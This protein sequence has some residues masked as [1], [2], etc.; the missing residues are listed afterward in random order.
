MTFHLMKK[1][2]SCIISIH[3]FTCKITR[4]TYLSPCKHMRIEGKCLTCEVKEDDDRDSYKR[5]TYMFVVNITNSRRPE[6]SVSS[7][8]YF[9]TDELGIF[10]LLF[11]LWL[12]DLFQQCFLKFVNS[13]YNGSMDLITV[14]I[15]ILAVIKF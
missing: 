3:F 4:Y 2:L 1:L 8:F 9:N 6:A 12:G 7:H 14:V 13:F 11:L 15:Y 5:G 10:N